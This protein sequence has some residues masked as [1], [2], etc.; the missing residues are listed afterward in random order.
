MD[1][2]KVTNL[3]CSVRTP[4]GK[5]DLIHDVSFSIGA[6]ERWGIVGESGCGKS[7][8]SL[9]MT[10]LLPDNISAE[11]RV[12]F[13]GIDLLNAS[14]K[15]IRRW[16][17]KK[18]A[19]IFQNPVKA[20]NPIKRIGSQIEEVMGLHFSL[21]RNQ[22]KNRT[23]ELLETVQL[24]PSEQFYSRF[25]HELSGGQ[26]QRVAIAIA[27]ACEPELII[28]DEPTTAL[29]SSVQKKILELIISLTKQHKMSLLLISHDIG[30]VTFATEK[31]MV[32]YSG[33]IVETLPAKALMNQTSHPYSKG[34]LE[35]I[36]DSARSDALLKTISGQ[37]VSPENRPSG[38]PFHPRCSRQIELCC[39]VNPPLAEL[40]SDHQISCHN[41]LPLPVK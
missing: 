31:I 3:S 19:M 12:M 34:L 33:Q 4:K 11:G 36:P 29:D 41:P 37:V 22:K 40:S 14:E 30:V 8:T 27:L 10:G 32:M 6:G 1:F 15:K 20:L 18:I 17:G 28:A 7:L 21:R 39:S 24:T 38:C 9:A 26:L 2:L 35:S 16:R 25:P 23:M 5:I 13:Q